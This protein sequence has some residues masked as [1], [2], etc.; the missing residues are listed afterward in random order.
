MPKV[1]RLGWICMRCVVLG[2][3]HDEQNHGYSVFQS[4]WIWLLRKLNPACWWFPS[5]R[6]DQR[7]QRYRVSGTTT[8]SV[9]HPRKHKLLMQNE[10]LGAQIS[11]KNGGGG[12]NVLSLGCLVFHGIVSGENLWATSSHKICLLWYK[13]PRDIWDL[14][15]VDVWEL[16]PPQISACQG[17][18]SGWWWLRNKPHMMFLSWLWFQWFHFGK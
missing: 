9:N 16:N 6:G 17:Q 12:G 1:T 2:N 15:H 18:P 3:L 11:P 14:W 13:R 10:V 5:L 4:R 7:N 8:V